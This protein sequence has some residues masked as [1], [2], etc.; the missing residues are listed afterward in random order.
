M[1]LTL[2]GRSRRLARALSV[3]ARGKLAMV[4][5]LPWGDQPTDDR[6]HALVRQVLRLCS[7]FTGKGM[8][9]DHH[10]VLGQPQGLSPEA[11]RLGKRLGN[12]S[13]RGAAPLF[14]FDPV[15]ET[16][17]GTGPSIGDRVDDRITGAG[18]LVQNLIGRWQTLADFPIRD[19]LRHAIALLQQLAQF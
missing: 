6:L 11:C 17:R 1:S 18:Q 10:G 7:G 8:L 14:G 19:H 4:S 12:D 15:V 3:W 9:D 2:P 13:D 5:L 16:P